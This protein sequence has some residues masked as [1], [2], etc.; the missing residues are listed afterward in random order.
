MKLIAQ[1]IALYLPAV[2]ILQIIVTIGSAIILLKML[3]PKLS[4]SRRRWGKIRKK[5]REI[6]SNIWAMNKI[7]N[8]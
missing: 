7:P 4:G 1:I 3:V 6:E 5:N 2:D 8:P